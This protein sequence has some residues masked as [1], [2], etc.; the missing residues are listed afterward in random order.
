MKVLVSCFLILLLTYCAGEHSGTIQ[1]ADGVGIHYKLKGHGDICLIFIHGWSGTS[2]IWDDQ[3]DYFSDKYK[4]VTIDLPG[5]GKSGRNR[6]QWTIDNYGNDVITIIDKL[7]LESAVLIGHSMGGLTAMSAATQGSDKIIGLVIVD[8]VTDIETYRTKSEVEGLITS[9]KVKI[10]KGNLK[11]LNED[12][13]N[14]ESAQRYSD[15]LP[16]E[17]PD[18]WWDMLM[19]LFD[20]MNDDMKLALTQIN[21]P[22]ILINS[23]FTKTDIES[24]Q[25]YN[26]SVTVNIISETAHYLFWDKPIEFNEMLLTSIETKLK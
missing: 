13:V 24:I 22:I 4:V 5:F 16:E 17:I 26:S 10:R 14:P 15:I 3:V 11:D 25:K 23:D 21:K 8:I 9:W 2:A 6:Q 18:F 12:H 7:K 19:L 1:S 20:W